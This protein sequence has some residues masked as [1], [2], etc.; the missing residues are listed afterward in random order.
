MGTR[1]WLDGSVVKV[2]EERNDGSAVPYVIR[3][4]DSGDTVVAPNDSDDCVVKGAARFAVGDTV[5]ANHEQEYKKCKIQEISEG[6]TMTSYKAKLLV[7]KKEVIDAP[8]DLNRFLRPIC[9][10]EK[11][12]KVVANVAQKFVPGTIE[13]C[14]HPNWVYAVRLDAGNVVFC[15]EDTDVFVKK[16]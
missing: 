15:P 8:E 2:W 4:K 14:Y 16:R 6:R 13:A 9:R 5:M 3:I 10:F 7:G 1:G 11:G 12:T